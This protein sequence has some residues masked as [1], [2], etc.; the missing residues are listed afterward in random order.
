ME[1]QILEFLPLL[2]ESINSLGT[3]IFYGLCFIGFC[4]AIS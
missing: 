4:T 3:A 1:Q 2:I